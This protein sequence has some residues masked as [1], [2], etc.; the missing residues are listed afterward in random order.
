MVKCLMFLA[1]LLTGG[2]N[3]ST[4]VTLPDTSSM[5]KAVISR[6]IDGDTYLVTL[7]TEGKQ[8]VRVR[9]IGVDTPESSPNEKAIRDAKRSGRDVS[10]IVALGK[11]ATKFVKGVIHTGDTV[12]LELDVQH[13]DRYGRLLAYVWLRDG[14]MLNELLVREGY[15]QVATFPPNVKYQDRFVEAQRYAREQGRGLWAKAAVSQKKR[16]TT[17]TT[18]YKYVASKNSRVFH[19]IWCPYA[20]KIKPSNRVYFKTR[21]EA[22]RSGRRPCKKCKP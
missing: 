6:V 19:Y 9:L 7:L 10:T 20:Q 5:L 13:T 15:A 14:R 3:P 22:I 17:A 16:S 8:D 21:E 1:F 4:V 12:Y 18:K 11:K 2:N